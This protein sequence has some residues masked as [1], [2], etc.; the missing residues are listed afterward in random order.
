MNKL[1][2]TFILSFLSFSLLSQKKK[3]VYDFTCMES[4]ATNWLSDMEKNL[5]DSYGSEVSLMEEKELGQTLLTECKM[6]YKFIESGS[7]LHNLKKIL[8][9]LKAQIKNPKGFDYEIYYIDDKTINAFTAG[10]KIFFTSGMYKFCL[11]KNEIASIIGHEIS[12]NELGHIKQNISKAKTYD[13]YLGKEFGEWTLL[14]SNLLTM[15]FNQK[16]ETHCDLVGIDLAQGA[17]YQS[18]NAV[19]LWKRMQIKDGPESDLNFLSTHPYS[20]RRAECARFH[21]QKNYSINCVEN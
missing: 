21:L 20:G 14:I 13:Y 6:E 12:H 19:S 11:D 3:I 2:F 18:C 16:N 15:S 1:I 4:S 7:E 9:S 8:K 10:G 5:I 17:G